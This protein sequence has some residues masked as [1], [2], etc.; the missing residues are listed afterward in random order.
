MK[1]KWEDERDTK[2]LEEDIA[3]LLIKR[4]YSPI[5]KQIIKQSRL[6]IVRINKRTVWRIEH[7]HTRIHV[8]NKRKDKR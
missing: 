7:T 1:K 8:A 5:A 6:V 3:N 2:D 4:R